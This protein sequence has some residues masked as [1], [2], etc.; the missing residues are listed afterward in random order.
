M[1]F[2]SVDLPDPDTPVTETKSPSG[3]ETSISFKLFSLAPLTT[4]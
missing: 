1:S 2:T 3:M 4:N